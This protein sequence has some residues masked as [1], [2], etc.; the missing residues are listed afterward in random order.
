MVDLNGEP[1]EPH[2]AAKRRLAAAVEAAHDEI[3]A[4]SHRIHAHPEPAF[5]E[6]QAASWVAEAMARHG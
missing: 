3:I 1:A 2:A 6:H 5:E 4:L